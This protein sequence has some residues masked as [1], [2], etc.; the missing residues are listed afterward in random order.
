MRLFSYQSCLFH[1]PSEKETT[2]TVEPMK[3]YENAPE[4]IKDSNLFKQIKNSGK[5]LVMENKFEQGIVEATAGDVSPT[6]KPLPEREFDAEMAN[7]TGDIE[8]DPN[9]FM[10]KAVKEKKDR[11]K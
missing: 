1:H 2:F 6:S 7:T 9:T 11:V 8:L 10:P 3:V 4:W 5:L